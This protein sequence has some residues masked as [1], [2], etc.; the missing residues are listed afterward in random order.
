MALPVDGFEALVKELQ[1][2]RTRVEVLEKQ[3]GRSISFG[4]SYRI[5]VVGTG[6]A[7]VLQA[8]RIADNNTVQIAP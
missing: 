7:A 4:T 1:S 3:N 5:Q 8:V 6:A 2:L